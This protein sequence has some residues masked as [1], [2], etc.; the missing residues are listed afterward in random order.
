MNLK[1]ALAILAVTTMNSNAASF[2]L[3]T[4]KGTL[5]NVI[6]GQDMTTA[7]GWIIND[8]A[9]LTNIADNAVNITTT[10]TSQ[11]TLTGEN[12][13]APGA[14]NSWLTEVSS[15]TSGSAFTMELSMRLNDAASGFNMFLGNGANRTIYSIYDDR[16]VATNFNGGLKTIPL[17]LNDGE[18]HTFRIAT[19]SA[20]TNPLIHFWVDGVR[21]SDD[22]G[23]VFNSGTDDNRFIF[24]DTTSGAFGDN[25]DVD[26]AY[27]AYNAGGF[28]PVAVP[29]PSSLALLGFGSL[30]LILR[31]RK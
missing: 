4:E 6:T 27:I 5:D 16:V 19:D 25:L 9:T 21:V 29:E 7:N 14:A 22:N 18:Y 1:Y 15:S 12:A 20:N 10:G 13:T 24:G 23:G 8:N 28:S 31:R 2:T 3:F 17:T 30:V 11:S 26:I